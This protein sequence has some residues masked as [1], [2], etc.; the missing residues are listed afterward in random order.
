MNDTDLI[1]AVIQEEGGILSYTENPHDPPTRAGITFDTF[2]D[3]NPGATL[4]DLKKCPLSEIH[5]IYREG[6]LDRVRGAPPAVVPALFS[7]AVNVGV[8]RAVILC[9][10]SLNA[11]SL[12]SG[13]F[14]DTDGVF[15]PKTQAAAE[16]AAA[17]Y[18]D[19]ALVTMFV[20]EWIEFYCQI[21]DQKAPVY[22][23]GWLNRSMKYLPRRQS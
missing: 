15:G 1:N 5:R 12:P 19:D 4:D 10:Q 22:I 14:L 18:S 11:L 21:S 9:Q 23:K 17:T 7:C 8:K 20:R 16:V 13:P 6:Y 3:F 2:C